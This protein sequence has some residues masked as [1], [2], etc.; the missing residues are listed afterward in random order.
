MKITKRK[1]FLFS[2]AVLCLSSCGAN[3]RTNYI[4]P[5][6]YSGYNA[7]D[8]TMT[9]TLSVTSIDKSE[10]QEAKGINVIKDLVKTGY[11][12]LDFYIFY[13][14]EEYKQFD[15]INLKDAYKGSKGTPIKYIDDNKTVLSPGPA[16][17]DDS[18][19]QFY[20]VEAFLGEEHTDFAYFSLKNGE[21]E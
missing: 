6:N 15:F 7:Y 12:K 16:P 3:H 8:K 9:C 17:K 4:I 13:A 10:Y 11:Y 20:S 1:L 19:K 18:M 2:T 21:Q 14:E 5:G